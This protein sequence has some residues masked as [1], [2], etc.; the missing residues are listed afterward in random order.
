[1]CSP[2]VVEYLTP[3]LHKEHEWIAHFEPGSVIN[4]VF[5]DPAREFLGDPNGRV[6]R[7]SLLA[8]SAGRCA[9]AGDRLAT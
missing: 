3:T 9:L 1:M 7:R 8:A 4:G 2:A 6:G 5:Y